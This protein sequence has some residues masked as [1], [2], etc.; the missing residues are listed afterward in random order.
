MGSLKNEVGK[1]LAGVAE[2]IRSGS[3]GKRVR[4]G[5]TVL[6]SEHGEAELIKAARIAQSSFSDFEVILIGGGKQEDFQWHEADNLNDCHAKM[7][8]LFKDNAINGAVT[9]HYSFPLGVGTVGK[10]VTPATG[11]EMILST[12]TGTSH[13]ARAAAMVKNAVY[14]IS[15]AKALG[16]EDPT[17]GILNLDNAPQV[18]KALEGMRE[19]GFVFRFT[20]SARADGGALMRGNDLLQGVPDVMV[21]DT[22]TGNLLI[23]M[24]ASFLTGG[25]YES[26]GYGYGPCLGSEYPYLVSIISRASG[27]PVI[28][29]A[30]KMTADAAAGDLRGRFAE[31]LGAAEKAGLNQAL[32]SLRPRAAIETA[33]ETVAEPPAKIANQEITGIDILEVEDAKTCLWSKSIYAKT[34]MGC[35][36]PVVMVADEDEQKARDILKEGG[37]L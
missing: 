23:K 17:V 29:N 22:L 9:L 36:G 4:I 3:F 13:P 20:E 21:T 10:V 16:N 19:K 6:G 11:R 1:T 32:D 2:G 28:A 5:L 31:T 18:Q 15:V 34:G 25:G 26:V 33:T 24:F 7:E 27:A 14:G 12:T 8:E 35:T 37:Y 30:L